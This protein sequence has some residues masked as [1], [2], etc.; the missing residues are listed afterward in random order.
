VCGNCDKFSELSESA[1]NNK[2]IKI[3]EVFGEVRI[4]A[5]NIAW[6]HHPKDA[7]KLALTGKYDVVFH[8]HTHIPWEESVENTHI[9]NPGTLAGMFSKATFAMY[10]ESLGASELI[11]VEKI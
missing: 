3:F 1:R 9:V 7:R 10:D 5:K 6:T 2:H 11:L 8:G 4:G